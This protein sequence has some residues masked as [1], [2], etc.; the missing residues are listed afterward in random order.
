MIKTYLP[1]LLVVAALALAPAWGED[2]PAEDADQPQPAENRDGA[3][4]VTVVSVT[5]SAEYA[6]IQ[7]GQD[8]DWKRIQADASLPIHSIIRTGFRTK[9]ELKFPDGSTV[10]VDRV[11]KIGIAKLRDRQGAGK[12]R[13]GLKYG[14]I[15]ADVQKG[16]AAGDVE[17]VTPVATLSVAGSKAE[18]GYS[19]DNCLGVKVQQGDWKIQ[20]Y[21]SARVVSDSEWG[22]CYLTNYLDLLAYHRDSYMADGLG[23]TDEDKKLDLEHGTGR[24][25]VAIPG[26]PWIVDPHP[27]KDVT[28][29]IQTTNP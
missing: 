19:V 5:G 28:K 2:Q 21:C 7:E 13:I 9:V 24:G 4:H 20:R 8:L 25:W 10:T 15:R 3:D 14:T 6:E 26:S 17:V 23:L 29:E 22:D 1:Y 12:T 27:L 16:Q 11:T 18:I